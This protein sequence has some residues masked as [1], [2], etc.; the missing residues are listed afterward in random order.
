MTHDWTT[1]AYWT[2]FVL[3]IIILATA[4]VVLLQIVRGRIDLSDVL[5]EPNSTKAS[6]S[7]FQFLIFTFVIA[8]LFLLLSIES[9]T[10][11]NIPD[12][13]LALLGIS[14][15]SYAVSKGITAGTNQNVPAAVAAAATLS[16]AKAAAH[17]AETHANAAKIAAD[18]VKPTP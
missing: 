6:L 12:S 7:R 17:E 18:S 14:A 16:A 1:L 4:G 11:V 10:F 3:M 5:T 13:V 2:A 9:G 8:G 15:G